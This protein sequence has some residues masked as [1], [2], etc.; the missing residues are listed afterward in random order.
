MQNISL[1]AVITDVEHDLSLWVVRPFVAVQF[2]RKMT[3]EQR[4]EYTITRVSGVAATATE[5]PETP[6]P[7]TALETAV[8]VA[9]DAMTNMLAVHYLLPRGSYVVRNGSREQVLRIVNESDGVYC[10]LPPKNRA[11]AVEPEPPAAA[12]PE[13][14]AAAEPEEPYD[15]ISTTRDVDDVADEFDDDECA[16]SAAA[17]APEFPPDA[18]HGEP[19]EIPEFMLQREA[20][21]PGAKKQKTG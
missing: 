21:Q 13:P 8:F 20:E 4:A 14:P 15:S 5:V 7:E 11:A 19:P 2:D 18:Q 3:K 16:Q 6:A 10:T 17:A 9:N 1:P 12:E